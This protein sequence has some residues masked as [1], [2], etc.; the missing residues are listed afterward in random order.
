MGRKKQGKREKERERKSESEDGWM[1][2]QKIQFVL[3]G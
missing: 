2:D 3:S 1:R